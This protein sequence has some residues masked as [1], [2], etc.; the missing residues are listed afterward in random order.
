MFFYQLK[1]NI[2]CPKLSKIID[3]LFTFQG[4]EK[5]RKKQNMERCRDIFQEKGYKLIVYSKD[6][7]SFYH[8]LYMTVLDNKQDVTPKKAIQKQN[9]LF[10]FEKKNPMYYHLFLPQCIEC[11]GKLP[12]KDCLS[13]DLKIIQK[14]KKN[15]TPR[16]I[17]AAAEMLQRNICVIR[18]DH[19]VG[20]DIERLTGYM[21]AP[22][23]KQ[24]LDMEP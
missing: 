10:E 24:L 20:T 5:K 2:D 18:F 19:A 23:N 22:T 1:N 12:P 14:G 3:R 8:C 11:D 9:D 7:Y 13:A 4:L 16:E 21:F 17:F 6:N 15:P